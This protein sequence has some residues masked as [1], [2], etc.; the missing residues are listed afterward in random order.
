MA[1]FP[2]GDLSAATHDEKL[3]ISSVAAGNGQAQN[4]RLIPKINHQLIGR[5]IKLLV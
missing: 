4:N 3:Q 2:I 5:G 1:V